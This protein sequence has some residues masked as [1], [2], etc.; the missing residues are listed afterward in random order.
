VDGAE[1]R[2]VSVELVQP[3]LAKCP[4]CGR[5]LV[6][7]DGRIREHLPRESWSEKKCPGSGAPVGAPA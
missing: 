2:L 1:G 5:R 6:V 4:V 7:R 3:T